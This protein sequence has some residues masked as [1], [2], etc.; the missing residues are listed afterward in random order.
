M[1]FVKKKKKQGKATI[2][3]PSHTPAPGKSSK[4]KKNP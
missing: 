2:A 1:K 4:M 3:M